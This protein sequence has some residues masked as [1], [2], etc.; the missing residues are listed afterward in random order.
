MGI[1]KN[2]VD[3]YKPPEMNLCSKNAILAHGRYQKC[4]LLGQ[5]PFK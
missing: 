4:C 3:W 1:V 5:A 2:V